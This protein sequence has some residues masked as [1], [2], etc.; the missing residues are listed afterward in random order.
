[1]PF[2]KP[3]DLKPTLNRPPVGRVLGAVRF[4]PLRDVL[5]LG[6]WEVLGANLHYSFHS[7]PRAL[8]ERVL[9]VITHRPSL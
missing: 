9:G 1:V 4:P 6:V 7:V 3:S 8:V 2:N 5:P